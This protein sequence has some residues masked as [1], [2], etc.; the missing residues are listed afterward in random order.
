MVDLPPGTSRQQGAGCDLEY[1]DV[2][3]GLALL[4]LDT[5]FTR[6]HVSKVISAI[7]GKHAHT[8]DTTKRR[9]SETLA[10]LA[11]LGVIDKVC[12]SRDVVPEHRRCLS[13]GSYSYVLLYLAAS[14]S[15]LAM[16]DDVMIPGTE[17]ASVLIGS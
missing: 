13:A 8:K 9:V 17:F 4:R 10:V 11:G 1:E 14:K 15:L 5:P 3:V 6:E 16:P 12:A 7:K 2:V